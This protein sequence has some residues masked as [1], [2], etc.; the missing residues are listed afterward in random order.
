M[1]SEGRFALSMTLVEDDFVIAF[2]PRVAR[3]KRH[4]LIDRVL[5]RD[6]LPGVIDI[7]LVCNEWIVVCRLQRFDFCCISESIAK[8]EIYPKVKNSK[9]SNPSRESGQAVT[10]E[11]DRRSDK[12]FPPTI[13]LDPVLADFD[14]K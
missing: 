7:P 3:S 10:N 8:T 6:R 13:Q 1:P 9:P 4:L 14:I 11:G 12:T 2:L 5:I